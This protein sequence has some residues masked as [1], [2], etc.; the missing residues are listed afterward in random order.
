MSFNG[1]NSIGKVEFPPEFS[2]LV[3]LAREISALGTK[4]NQPTTAEVA[5][6][7]PITSS[8]PAGFDFSSN[9]LPKQHAQN[10]SM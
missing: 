9:F 1:C 8:F 6:R 4:Q 10:S 3:I 5:F 2:A 7:Q